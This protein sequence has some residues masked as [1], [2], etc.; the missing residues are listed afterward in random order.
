MDAN[1]EL[2]KSSS[3]DIEGLLS[4]YEASYLG[5]SEEDVMSHAKE[6]TTRNLNRSVSQLSPKLNNKVFASLKL[7]RH[8]RMERLEARRYIEEYSNEVDHNPVVLEFAK[9]DYN[10]VQS[11]LRRELVEVTRWWEHLGLSSKLGFVRDRHVECFL[12]TVGLLPEL[13]FSGSR[14]ELA[15]TIAILLVIDDIYDT[16]GSYDDLVLFTEA[17]QRWDLNAVE[18]LPEYMKICFEA[19]YN[20]N[21]E[22]CDKVLREQGF[23]VQPFLR[24]TWIDMAEAYMVEAEWVKTGRTPTLK[25][26]IENGVTT[27][28]TCMAL[29][30]LFFLVSDRLTAENTRYLLDPYPKFFTLAGTI[31]RLWDDLGT[32][33]EEQ[34]RGDVL[35]SIHLLMKEKNIKCE[36]EG[37][38]EIL[39]LIYGLWNDLNVELV[40]P[41]A[42]L[43]P[44]IKV[45][46]NMSR[47]SQVVYQHN[48]DSY[49]SSVENYVQSL[50]YKP[51]D[52]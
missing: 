26:Y 41:D 11:V 7:P 9:Y 19:L 3:E 37:R 18:Q 13:R 47:A 48:D 10:M 31:L 12:W 15:K 16:Y 27:S 29:V 21:N 2:N 4:L 51:I 34:E 23:G 28:G 35:S 42:V 52:I 30:H 25:D 5:S 33:K 6:N 20:T 36:E 32:V 45:A 49:L 50:F 39:Q 43:F 14:I 8:M 17:I 38:K 24:K 44:I 40:A 22:I 46:L 1:G